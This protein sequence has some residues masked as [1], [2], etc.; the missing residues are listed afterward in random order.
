MLN[1]IEF[2]VGQLLHSS[3]IFIVSFLAPWFIYIGK[4]FVLP[5][6]T[7]RNR[8]RKTKQEVTL[9]FVYEVSIWKPHVIWWHD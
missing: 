3:I 6:E 9:S 8:E 5:L 2:I 1:L 7:K 4:I